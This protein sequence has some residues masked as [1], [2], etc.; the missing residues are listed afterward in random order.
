MRRFSP[1]YLAYARRDLWSDRSALANLGLDDRERVL[2]VGCGSGELTRILESAS[3]ATVIGL[4][5]DSSHLARIGSTG[6]VGEATALPFE[7][8][9]FDLVVCQALLVNLPDPAAVVEEFARVSSD[10]VAAIEPDNSAVTVESSVPAEERLSRWARKAY[11]DG[12]ETDVALGAP[13]EAFRAAGLTDIRTAPRHHEKRTEP[14]YTEAELEAAVRKA[15]GSRLDE[16]RESLLAGGMG[17]TEFDDLRTEWRKMGRAVIE[18][19]LKGSYERT[20][21]V[22]YHVTVGRIAE[23]D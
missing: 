15:T 23:A 5:A 18:A 3:R 20:E 1:E 10:Q 14:P 17:P 11:I 7:K 2:D 22:P 16:Q 9:S 19:M 8:G 4:D 13:V 21:T 6:V 12:V